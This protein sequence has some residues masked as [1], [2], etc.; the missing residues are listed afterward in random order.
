M[1]LESEQISRD[2]TGEGHS[3]TLSLG[4]RASAC[5]LSASSG[6]SRTGRVAG[7]QHLPCAGK[8]WNPG[9]AQ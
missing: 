9:G 4:R 6:P 2:Y 8:E 5:T 7:L 3:R 1:G